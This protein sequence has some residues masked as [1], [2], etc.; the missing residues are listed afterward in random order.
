MPLSERDISSGLVSKREAWTILGCSRRT[1]DRMIAAGEI[2]TV[3]LRA[4]GN[5]RISRAALLD[6]LNRTATSRR[7]RPRKGAA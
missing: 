5:V 4:G 6:A 7:G 1:L 3:R 2:E